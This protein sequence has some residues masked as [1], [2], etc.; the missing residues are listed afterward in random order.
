LVLI[1]NINIMRYLIFFIILLSCDKYPAPPVGTSNKYQID[2]LSIDNIAATTATANIS[3][4]AMNAPSIISKGICWDT[5]NMPTVDKNFSANGSTISGFSVNISGLLPQQNYYCRPYVRTTSGIIYGEMKTF[6]TVA[7]A[8]P[9][10][11]STSAISSITMTSAV[12]GGTILSSGGSTITDKGVCWS[13][14]SLPTILN[15]KTSNGSGNSSFVSSLTGLLLNTT[16]YV[17]AYATSI[18]GTGYGPQLQFTTANANASTVSTSTASSI[19]VSSAIVS[20]NV[21]SAG[22]GTVSARGIC[23]STLAAPTISNSTITVGSG[24]GSFTA[25]L[26]GLNFNQ[27]YYARAFAT[28]QA[29]TAYGNQISFTTLNILLPTVTTNIVSAVLTT[30]AVS[31]GNISS[32]GGGVIT[33]R[34]VCWSSSTT[35]PTIANSKTIDGSGLGSFSSSITN[36]ITKTTYYVRAYATN[37]AG[38]SY[39]VVR[40]FI[41]N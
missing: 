15:A 38:T 4:S 13:T 10:V 36:L 5:A 12:S 16:Y 41:T 40:Q 29:G 24:T 2:I 35:S 18:A 26:T 21:S 6:N 3:F 39:G 27:I 33:S 37:Q 8:V 28:N 20:G 14:S 30:S 31:G 23:W 1:F 32:D 7:L 11:S 17:R 34:G 9:I 22:G 19:T 25:T